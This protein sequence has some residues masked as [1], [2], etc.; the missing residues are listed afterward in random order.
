MPA[1]LSVAIANCRKRPAPC[2]AVQPQAQRHVG[3]YRQPHQIGALKQHR[4]A[5]AR[6]L[7]YRL[8]TTKAQL[9]PLGSVTGG[10][11][12]AYGVCLAPHA[13][14]LDAYSILK[15]GAVHQIRI[16]LGAGAP[17]GAIV[18]SL[19]LATQTEGCVTD[20]RSGMLYVGEEDVGIWAFPMAETARSGLLVAPVDG[21]H[22]FADVEG[23]ALIQQGRRGG[24]LVASSQ[25]D[26]G[27]ALFRLPDFAPAGRFRI[28]K[29]A[30]GA[31][32]QNDGIALEAGSFG[33]KLPEGLFIAQDGHNAPLAQNF[34]LVSWGDVRAALRRRK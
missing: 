4:L 22:L 3:Q 11:G 17:Q 27:Y 18:R 5:Q 31:T 6:L 26:N 29:G 1:H 13:G 14:G 28:T 25:G 32:E 12:E 16:T 15:H 33:A 10:A 8:D 34:K 9:Q 2:S 30:F 21:R 20:P 7:L 19:Q 24:W 23:L